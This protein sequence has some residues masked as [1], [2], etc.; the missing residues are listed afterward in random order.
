MAH[1]ETPKYLPE[2]LSFRYRT[3]ASRY[4]SWS[5]VAVYVCNVSIGT[6]Y[7]YTS[8]HLLLN[9]LNVTFLKTI[10][11]KTKNHPN[12]HVQASLFFI[13]IATKAKCARILEWQ[14]ATNEK[15]KPLDHHDFDSCRKPSLGIPKKYSVSFSSMTKISDHSEPN[16]N[17][18][19]A[20]LS[21]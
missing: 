13:F 4:S 1:K 12:I 10:E 15:P 20:F 7:S 18:I 6:T 21:L 9:L 17:S 8:R 14:K 2:C 11:E 19:V 16:F 5:L 3:L